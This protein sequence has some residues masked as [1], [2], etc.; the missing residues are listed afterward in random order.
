[1][2]TSRKRR[3]Y[4][5]NTTGFAT[6]YPTWMRPPADDR[7]D[8]GATWGRE[9]DHRGRLLAGARAGAAGLTR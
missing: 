5:K 3:E 2:Q 8:D 9:A 6:G 7:A 1:M 4:D